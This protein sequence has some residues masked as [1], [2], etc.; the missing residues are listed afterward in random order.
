MDSQVRQNADPRRHKTGGE[1]RTGMIR[2][3]VEYIGRNG[4]KI[5]KAFASIEEATEFTNRL[6]ERI[7]KGTCGGYIMTEV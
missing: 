7:E 2:V 4:K 3:L 6:D 5:V 1:R